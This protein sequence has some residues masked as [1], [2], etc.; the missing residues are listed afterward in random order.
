MTKER[1][2]ISSSL[3][4]IIPRLSSVDYLPNRLRNCNTS[5]FFFCQPI[6]VIELFLI[7][8]SMTWSGWCTCG[9][10][11]MRSSKCPN[12]YHLLAWKEALLF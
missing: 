6:S 8:I 7:I 1:I 2:E 10:I 9:P 12:H 11:L 5:N 4:L 3:Y